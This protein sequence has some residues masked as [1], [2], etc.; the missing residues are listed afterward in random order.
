MKAGLLG[1]VWWAVAAGVVWAQGTRA[2]STEAQS[3]AAEST[4]ARGRVAAQDGEITFVFDWPVQTP[5]HYEIAVAPDGTG[6][7]R[8]DAARGPGATPPVP[9]PLVLSRAVMSRLAGVRA[10]L[11]SGKACETTAKHLAQ[12]G[13]K[14][15]RLEQGGKA[16]TCSYNYSDDK[17]IAEATATFQA[18]AM[19]MEEAPRLEHLHRFDRLGLDAELAVFV[20]SVRDGRA[21]EVGNIAPTLRSLAADADLLER[22]R[23]RAADLLQGVAGTVPAT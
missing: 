9:R 22:V 23:L 21:I 15:L 3:P 13:A 17:R 11:V 1:A 10:V 16:L 12:T 2:Q 5:A 14:T 19:T 4:V 20:Q 8:E 18:I 7:Y 6:S